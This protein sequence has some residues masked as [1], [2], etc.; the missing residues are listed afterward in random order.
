MFL[1][2]KH[3]LVVIFSSVIVAVVLVSTL[4]VYS[5]Y[6]QFKE[7]SF[8][9]RY[10]NSIYK[11]TA[12]LFRKDIHI[13]NLSVRIM[14]DKASSGVPVIEGSIKNGTGKTLTS[15][16]MEISFT[17]PDGTV[18]YKGWL[19]PL[20]EKHFGD[21]TM[22]PAATQA[23]YVLLPGETVSFRHIMRNC[24]RDIIKQISARSNFAKRQPKEK[25]EFAHSIVGLSVL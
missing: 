2:K 3:I 8:A 7:D 25:S 10:R 24:P 9:L 16:L 21:F 6:M 15:V 23:G 12:E 1:K 20:G 22:P 4:A 19:H 17:R 13:S 11:L 5:L 18:S 14:R